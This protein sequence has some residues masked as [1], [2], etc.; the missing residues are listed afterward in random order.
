MSYNPS[1]KIAR[2]YECTSKSGSTYYRGRMGAANV[3]LLKSNETSDSGQ[4][5]WDLLVQEVERKQDY[6]PQTGKPDH[7]APPADAGH[8]ASNGRGVLDD[9]VPFAPPIA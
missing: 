6:Q 3:V 2:L 8:A 1:V 4:A 5:I 9:E 7:Q